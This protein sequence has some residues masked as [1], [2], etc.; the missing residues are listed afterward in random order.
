MQALA[1]RLATLRNAFY[2]VPW[3]VPAWGWPELRVT[4]A[5]LGGGAV[6]GDYPRQF[7]AAVGMRAGVANA[8]PV[9]RGRTAITLA[10]R[11]CAAG[12]GADVVLPAYCCQSV[13]EAVVRAGARPVFADIDA[14][15]HV[16]PATV[17]A[18][19]TSATRAVI[20]AHL[21]GGAAP[22]DAIA[23]A[24]AG[25][26]VALIDDAAQSFGAL[27]AGRPVGAFGDFG[28]VSCGPGKALAGA[29]GGV[30]LARDP[31]ALDRARAVPLARPAAAEVLARTASFWVWRRWRR[32]T[33]AASVVLNRAF[34]WR[35]R[36]PNETEAVLSNLEAGI[37]LAQLRAL[38]RNAALRREN[39]RR[40]LE[41]LAP[42]AE[43]VLTDLSAD[44]VATKLAIVLRPGLGT[45]ADLIRR[46]ARAGIEC[47]GGY[48]PVCPDDAAMRA[49]LPATFD[50]AP[51]VVCLP[52]E[53]ALR[54]PQR[55]ARIAA[56]A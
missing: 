46:L 42:L 14:S 5:C 22:V 4:L 40:L 17:A 1:S 35:A 20:V 15:G 49:R 19:M 33:L 53:S 23:G 51:R 29:A 21:Y 38:D 31:A 27:R 2:D 43:R 32:Y 25:T 28:V 39:G 11:A 50:L 16:S 52:I 13:L 44:G 54:Q 10:L 8:L 41:H 3:C 55:L 30:L 6:Q 9:N 12:P 47:Q 37:A 48:E 45:A 18:A 34:G 26:G 7:A 36:L 24:L 56:G